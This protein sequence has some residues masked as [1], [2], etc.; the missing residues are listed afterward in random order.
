MAHELRYDFQSR[1]VLH[2][3]RHLQDA[4]RLGARRGGC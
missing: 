3:A 1:S 4:I 2:A